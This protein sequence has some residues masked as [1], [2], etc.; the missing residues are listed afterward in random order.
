VHHNAVKILLGLQVSAALSHNI[1]RLTLHVSSFTTYAG[2]KCGTHV[3]FRHG[4]FEENTF[5]CAACSGWFTISPALIHTADQAGNDD[6]GGRLDVHN[7]PSDDSH[8]SPRPNPYDELLEKTIKMPLQHADP[9]SEASFRMRHVPDRNSN[10][11]NTNDPKIYTTRQPHADQGTSAASSDGMAHESVV[12]QRRPSP[13]QELRKMPT[14]QQIMGKLNDYVIGQ[15]EV[16]VA[17]SV[18]VYNHYKRIFLAESQQAMQEL[19]KADADDDG[20]IMPQSAAMNSHGPTL[21]D[22]NLGQFGSTTVQADSGRSFHETISVNSIVDSS[23]ARDVEDCEI[24]KSNILLLGPTGSGK[25]SPRCRSEDGA[26]RVGPRLTLA[27]VF[28]HRH[29]SSR[30][31]LGSL[32]FRL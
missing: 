25:V 11:N 30:L 19:R 22:M 26:Y 29:C 16:K 23:F 31:W 2:P 7:H 4:D 12:H 1:L 18:G 10:Q 27:F 6:G 9:S 21:Q 5:Y 24:D 32:T 20:F 8:E 13:E 14:P 17:L 28:L 3:T 15:K